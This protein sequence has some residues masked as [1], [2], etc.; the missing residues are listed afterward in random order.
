M[1]K[2]AQVDKF[3]LDISEIVSKKREDEY[4]SPEKLHAMIAEAWTIWLRGPR[5]RARVD[6]R[7]DFLEEKDLTSFDVP[8]M[9]ILLKVCRLACAPGG[10]N[11]DDTIMDIAGYAK[12]ANDLSTT[13]L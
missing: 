8:I 9:M 7:R 2:E 13:R 1:S 5:R 6:L 12:I 11:V 10:A 3:F 4:G